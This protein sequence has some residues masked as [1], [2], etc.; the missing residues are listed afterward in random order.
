MEVQELINEQKWIADI[1]KKGGCC[2]I[3]GY[4]EN[5]LIFER[6][7]IGGRNNS[8]LTITVCPNCHRELSKKQLSWDENWSNRNNTLEFKL[9]LLKISRAE[10]NKMIEAEIKILKGG[11]L[12]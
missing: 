5:P 2:L 11:D 4:T 6:H 8:D 1:I 7:H 3:C 12:A 10:I 9:K